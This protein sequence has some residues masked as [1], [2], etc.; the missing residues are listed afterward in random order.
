[1][2]EFLGIGPDDLCIGY[3]VAGVADPERAASYKASRQPL[4]SVVEWRL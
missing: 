4:D 1:M 3:F 2:H